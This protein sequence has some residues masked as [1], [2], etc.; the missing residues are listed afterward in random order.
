MSTPQTVIGLCGGLCPAPFL[1]ALNE[2]LLLT[3]DSKGS[4]VAVQTVKL[5]WTAPKSD[6]PLVVQ[7]DRKIRA[8]DRSS[9]S[10]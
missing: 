8:F 1:Q 2:K 6:K 3:T 7:G 10:N 5:E 9:L 4:K